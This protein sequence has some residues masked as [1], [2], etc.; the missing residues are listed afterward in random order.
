[1]TG[2][3]SRRDVR[4][5][6]WRLCSSCVPW[7]GTEAGAVTTGRTRFMYLTTT[8]IITTITPTTAIEIPALLL[9][10][11]VLPCVPVPCVS[12][13]RIKSKPHVRRGYEIDK[14]YSPL[15]YCAALL[16]AHNGIGLQCFPFCHGG[17][18]RS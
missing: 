18:W 11:V 3:E 8:I 4:I 17:V 14:T 9:F 12:V 6:F 16:R 15:P 7:F 5:S 2:N 13:A 10:S 1:M